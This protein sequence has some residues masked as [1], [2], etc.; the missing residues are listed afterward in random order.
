[1]KHFTRHLRMRGCSGEHISLKSGIIGDSRNL[2]SA[3]AYI[4][5]LYVAFVMLYRGNADLHR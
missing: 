2:R 1:M 3:I 5:S 4:L